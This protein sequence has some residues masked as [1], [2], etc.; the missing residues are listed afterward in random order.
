MCSGL[1]VIT[2]D[3]KGN[4]DFIEHK[5]NGFIYDNQDEELFANTI[6]E[7]FTKGALQ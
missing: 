3:G 4:K 6:I 1:P 5:V 7:L 2:L